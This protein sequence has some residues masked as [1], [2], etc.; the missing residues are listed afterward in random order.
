[1]ICQSPGTTR[2]FVDFV[3]Q[4][5]DPSMDARRPM[6]FHASRILLRI[7]ALSRQYA[8]GSNLGLTAQE[9]Q[10]LTLAQI[11]S[12]LSVSLASPDHKL[13]LG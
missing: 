11:P 5:P 6:L 9:Q 2:N 1:M 13:V 10:D 8:A 12:A 4:Q 3:T 7:A